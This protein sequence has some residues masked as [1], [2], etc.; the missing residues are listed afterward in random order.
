MT[1]PPEPWASV[2]SFCGTLAEGFDYCLIRRLLGD[3]VHIPTEEVHIRLEHVCEFARFV[4][5]Y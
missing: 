4:G 1:T 5:L 3:R 2:D